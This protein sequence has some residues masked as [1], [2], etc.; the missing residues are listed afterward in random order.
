MKRDLDLIRLVLLNIESGTPPD[1]L[2]AY[3]EEQVLYHCHLAIEAGLV[4]GRA[5]HN[6]ARVIVA[7][8]M[9][10]LTWEGHDFLDAA[11]SE[12]NWS[13]AKETIHKAGGSWTFEVMKALLVE[14]AKRSLSLIP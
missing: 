10:R 12:S 1:E 3:T 4:E 8:R 5:L 2:A 13:K 6:S 14:I 11:R 7:A 9:D